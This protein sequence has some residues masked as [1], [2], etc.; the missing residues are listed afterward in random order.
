MVNLTKQ[1][2]LFYMWGFHIF[3]GHMYVE[4]I[5]IFTFIAQTKCS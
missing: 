1:T 5:E 3:R 2:I 4:V